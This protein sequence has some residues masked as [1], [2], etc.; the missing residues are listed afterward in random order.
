MKILSNCIL[1]LVCMALLCVP[2]S[3]ASSVVSAY[4]NAR[5]ESD[6]SCQVE[7]SFQLQ[8]DQAQKLTFPLPKAA[9]NV[10]LNGNLKSPSVQA[11]RLLLSLGTLNAG[12]HTVNIGFSVSDTITEKGNVLT[13]QIPL[14]TG[15][16]LPLERFSF[17]VTLPAAPSATPTLQSNWGSD[18][19]AGLSVQVSG[20]TLSGTTDSRLLDSTELSIL[21]MGDRTLFPN[22]AG[23]PSALG[24]WEIAMIALIA[25]GALYYLLAMLPGFP[26]KVRVFSPPEGLSAGDLGT[27]LT[28]CG[29][30]L[31]MMVFSWA[32][33]GYVSLH[34]D[35]RGRVQIQKRLEMGSERSD[36]EN[37]AF[38]RL[39]SGRQSVDGGGMHY[40]LTYRKLAG[41]SPLLRRIYR[42]HS[43]NP[44]IVNLLAVLVGGC[45]G[46]VLS[47]NVYTAGAGT[48]LLAMALAAACALLSHLILSGS[49]CLP[50]GN[51]M[52][53]CIGAIAAALWIVLGFACGNTVFAVGM[54]GYELLVGLAAAVGGRRSELGQQYLAQIR[55]LRAQLTHG[56]IFDIQA[57][58]ARN[59]AYFFEMMPYAL[60]LGVEKR[61]ARRFGR[62]TI[63]QCDYLFADG[64]EN[65]TPTQWAVLLRRVA[66]RL[67]RR[68]QRLK[69]ET[70]LQ[71]TYG[72][73]KFIVHKEK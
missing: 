22:Y 29:T 27:C 63:A 14:L 41:K 36:F 17:S 23:Q 50:L 8:L 31:T 47:R 32:Q 73:A 49:R 37:H 35:A 24:L 9:K 18:A 34:L 60:A 70:L 10:R 3:A 13:A 43:G 46:I 38:H 39:F 55:G 68:Q 44:R 7:L 54:V 26:G 57:C 28:G 62:V 67:N 69:Y 15:F 64:Q 20:N 72:N 30:D 52:P 16:A 4:S 19:L 6:G 59:P 33:L 25:L 40:A 48:V 65:L 45:S 12:V 53:I 61:F 2:V 66:D 5:V 58:L 56:S 1:L 21:C 71:R 51:K 11:D 42:A